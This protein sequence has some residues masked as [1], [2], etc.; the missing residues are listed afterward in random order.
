VDSHSEKFKVYSFQSD[1][2]G[3]A[4][5][6]NICNW[7]QE[8]ATSHANSI[9]FGTSDLRKQGYFWAIYRWAIIID[10]YPRIFDTI[11]V[12]TWVSSQKGPFTERE[13]HI[14]DDSGETLVRASSLWFAVDSKLRKPVPISRIVKKLPMIQGYKSYPGMPEKVNVEQNLQII[15]NVRIRSYDFDKNNHVNNIR[16]LDWM[17]KSLPD[18][19][20]KYYEL[21]SFSVN[22]VDEATIDHDDLQIRGKQL[23]DSEYYLDVANVNQVFARMRSVWRKRTQSGR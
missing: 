21:N 7:L 16:Y 19:H 2:Y 23:T 6:V 1:L 8:T 20:I 11:Q 13:Y 9:G 15:E 17:L 10:K 14:E 5:V 12:K 18:K 22:F 3:K 4:S